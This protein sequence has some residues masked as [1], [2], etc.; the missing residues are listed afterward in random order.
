MNT[1]PAYLAAK[2]ILFVLKCLPLNFALFL[3]RLMGNMAYLFCAKQKRTG[4]LNLRAAF[5]CSKSPAELKRILRGSYKNL[6]RML[7]EIARFPKLNEDWVDSFVSIKGLETVKK[8][9]AKGGGLI[10][11][12]GHF[13]NWELASQV[14]SIKGYPM[15]VLV[16]KQKLNRL[17]ELLNSYRSA[18]NCEV[19]S[20]GVGVKAILRSLR[21]NNTVG[22]LAD[23]DVRQ[24]GV[25]VEFLGRYTSAPSGVAAIAM[26]TGSPIIPCFLKRGGGGRHTLFMI[27][28]LTIDS[29]G[30]KESVVRDC[31]Q[32]YHNLLSRYIKE[33]PEQ[34]FWAQKRWRSTPARAVIVLSDGKA[35]HL[36]QAKAV[37]RLLGE[38]LEKSGLQSRLP[39]AREDGCKIIEAGFRHKA[40]SA[41][42][43]ACL[44]LAFL[45]P[46]RLLLLRLFLTKESYRELI[47]SYADYVISCGSKLAGI[48]LAVSRE[49][50]AR[51]VVIMK[52]PLRINNFD[53]AVIPEHD[54]PGK[55]GKSG[56]VVVTAGAP[57]L[58]SAESIR[59]D[60]ETLTA[61]ISLKDGSILGVFFG[62]DSRHYS[63]EEIQIKRML[64]EIKSIAAECNS[65]LLATTSRRTG[66][67]FELLFE[68]SLAGFGGCKLLVLAS[69]N[70]PP[71]TIGG[72]LGLSDVVIVSF[73][74]LSM[75]CEAVSSQK[76]VVVLVPDNYQSLKD[77][78]KHKRLISSF[79]ARGFVKTAEAGSL[80]TVVKDLFAAEGEIKAPDDNKKIREALAGL[81]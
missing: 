46:L 79:T 44:T 18:N 50:G 81:I 41:L 37:S 10:F 35:G 31:L 69:K 8:A 39:Y 15:Q 54:R 80:K 78:S 70:N 49:N 43:N 33:S 52:P 47:S 9:K 3:G 51:S 19:V 61:K 1:Y 32:G 64:A 77:L 67:A 59:R 20:K 14:L 66:R 65:N 34:W 38:E 17:N 42:L 30:P 68:G 27:E 40:G 75:I 4:Y 53:L 63:Y 73:D 60:K 71:E 36:N 57:G 7:V 62:G 24:S 16:R 25:F 23:Q 11:L 13:G 74:S 72:I 5:S 2:F 48:N 22:M 21:K 12:T 29:Q 58:I 45:Q 56:R 26:K 76:R 28:E 6:G 55:F